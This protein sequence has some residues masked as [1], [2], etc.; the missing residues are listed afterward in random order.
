MSFV[1]KSYQFTADCVAARGPKN[2]FLGGFFI[3][4]GVSA[5]NYSAKCVSKWHTCVPQWHTIVRITCYM[6]YSVLSHS[7][8]CIAPT[9]TRPCASDGVA[10]TFLSL[11]RFPKHA[12]LQ[13]WK[14]EYQ[15]KEWR[16]TSLDQFGIAGRRS[17]SDHRAQ[18]PNLPAGRRAPARPAKQDMLDASGSDLLMREIEKLRRRAAECRS[19]PRKQSEGIGL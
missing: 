9:T 14:Y 1:W 8:E 18:V 19:S 12:M 10:T 13:E 3:F 16:S 4:L 7:S 11:H 6:E 17:L 5:R 15:T 2:F